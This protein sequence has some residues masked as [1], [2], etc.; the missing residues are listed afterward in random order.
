VYSIFFLPEEMYHSFC[1][2]CCRQAMEK[3]TQNQHI[4]SAMGEPITRGPW[5]S[6][7]IAVNHAGHSVSCTLPVLGPQGEG[8]LK[9]KAVRLGG[10]CHRHRNCV[11]VFTFL[12]KHRWIRYLTPS[13]FVYKAAISLFRYQENKA[14]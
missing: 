8:L 5:Y 13:V 9:F 3:A 6:A 11:Q 14:Y 12:T 10:V 1:Y 4:V 7:S 2:S